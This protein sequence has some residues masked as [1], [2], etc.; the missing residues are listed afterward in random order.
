MPNTP[1]SDQDTEEPVRLAYFFTDLPDMSGTFPH[2]EMIGMAR[3][4]FLPEIYCLRSTLATGPGAHA[5]RGRFPINRCGYFAPKA[6]RAL[7]RLGLASPIR[8]AAGIGVIIGDTWRS[9]R[10]LVKSLAILPKCSVFALELRKARPDLLVAYWA[11]LPGRAA[12]WIARFTGLPYATWAHAGADIYNRAHQTPAALR[13]ILS[14]TRVILTCNRTN[15]AYFETLLPLSVRS[16]VRYQPHGVD[17]STFSPDPDSDDAVRPGAEDSGASRPLRLISVGRSSRAKGFGHAVR[18]C[19]ILKDRGCLFTYRI[20]GGGPGQN[21]LAALAVELGLADRI[22]LPGALEQQQLPAEYRA[23]DVFLMPSVVGAGGAR[24]GLPNVLLEAMACG[25]AC[26]G[27]RAVGIPE[28]IEDGVTGLLVPPG[29]PEALANAV[30]RLEA[31]PTLRRR[32]GLAA[33][34]LVIQRYSRE[35]CMDQLAEIFRAA[36][37]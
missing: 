14:G 2:A 10:I 4:G 29:D 35:L 19:R 26:V 9:P 30:L 24:D 13:T 23:A 27:S 8:F 6:L 12:W 21:D 1:A 16:R 22:D 28:A 7:L 11:S 36:A 25:L 3:R 18:A 20:V 5:L 33:R 17:V 37:R 31:E 34:N 32:L 15:L